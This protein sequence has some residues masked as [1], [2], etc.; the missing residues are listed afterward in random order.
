VGQNIGTIQDSYAAVTV[1]ANI[2]AGGL[3]GDNRETIIN[4]Y[5]YGSI[6]THRDAKTREGDFTET[7]PAYAPSGIG[8]LVGAGG[9]DVVWRSYWDTAKH[10]DSDGGR[11]K[12]TAELQSPTA[13]TGI[14]AAWD[15]AIW[16]FGSNNQYPALKYDTDGVA[17]AYEFGRQGR[18][19][20]DALREH[21]LRHG[22]RRPD[23]SRQLG[24]V[25]RHPP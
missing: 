17:T 5:A 6:V 11:G 9:A 22:R 24:A 3:V 1:S 8:G 16:D 12:T 10:S 25:G 14:Y 18:S 2:V 21:R 13:A 7:T 23:R 15:A 4:S 19:A 20:P